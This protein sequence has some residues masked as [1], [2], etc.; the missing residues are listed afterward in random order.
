[1]VGLT[2]DLLVVELVCLLGMALSFALLIELLYD[3]Q[4]YPQSGLILGLI[5]CLYQ[6]RLLDRKNH[7]LELLHLQYWDQLA[8]LAL[9]R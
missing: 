9:Q 8:L 5:P 7:L 1:V 4:H 3:Q 2:L 6:Q